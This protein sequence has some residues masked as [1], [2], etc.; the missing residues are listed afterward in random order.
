MFDR[1]SS[2]EKRFEDVSE[3]LYE[4]DVVSDQQEYTKL[5]KEHKSLLPIVEKYR[6]YTAAKTTAEEAK[7]LLLRLGSKRFG[8]PDASSQAALTAV[9]SLEALEQLADRLLEVES[10]QELLA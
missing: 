7:A 4:P 10:W 6:E 5:M 1:L 2:V 3:K 8:V 9:T